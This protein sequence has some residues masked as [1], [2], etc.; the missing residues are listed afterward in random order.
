MTFHQFDHELP[1]EVTVD[2]VVR[3]DGVTMSVRGFVTVGTI[4]SIGSK[5]YVR[6]QIDRPERTASNIPKTNPL[7]AR[8][9]ER[10]GFLV[11][12]GKTEDSDAVMLQPG[13]YYPIHQAI[14]NGLL[15]ETTQSPN[16]SR[17]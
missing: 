16:H 6:S 8:E 14:R 9:L 13:A 15:T 1:E 7:S 3:I 5:F 17:K 4:Y 10:K 11:I 2:S 12:Y